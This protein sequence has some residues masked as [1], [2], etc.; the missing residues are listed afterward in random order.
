[1]RFLPALAAMGLFACGGDS[2]GT[3]TP[4]DV[5]IEGTWVLSFTT[6]GPCAP[7]QIS[8]ILLPDGTSP[9]EGSYGSYAVTCT[10]QP[11]IPVVAGTIAGYQVS[12]SNISIQFSNV[13]NNQ[14]F[15]VGTAG[16]AAM[17]GTFTWKSNIPGSSYD[18][19]GTF[20]G[21]KQ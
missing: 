4:G 16:S 18:V 15:L 13:G 14:K 9:N 11:A 1:M 19:A 20:T 6:I 7:S 8:L 2:G 3:G 21:A 5:D 12:G 17:S 10:G